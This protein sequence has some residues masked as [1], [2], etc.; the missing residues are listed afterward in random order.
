M[1][2]LMN[3]PIQPLAPEDAAS[4]GP[5]QAYTSTKDA[6]SS[7]VDA[8][9]AKAVEQGL[10]DPDTGFPTLKG[11]HEAAQQ[12][13]GALVAGT[14][15]PGV[16]AFHGSPHDFEAFDAG[17]IGTGEGAQAYG[18]GLYF[19]ENEG[20][21]KGYR[22]VLARAQ[23]PSDTVQTQQALNQAII[24]SNDKLAELL[25]SGVRFGSDE[26]EAALRP[27][28]QAIATL[29]EQLD[30]SPPPTGHMYEVSIN[31]NPDHFLDWD[32]PLSE[33]SRT[34]RKAISKDYPHLFDEGRYPDTLVAG[35]MAQARGLQAGTSMIGHN[36]V[37]RYGVPAKEMTGQD[38]WHLMARNSESLP[39]AS[40]ALKQAGIPGIRYLDQ[41][42][43]GA[44]E[45]TSNYVAFDAATIEILRKYGIAG[46][47]GAGAA[48]GQKQ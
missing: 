46:L 25:K 48:A 47:I 6:L 17:K 19:A 22:D 32:K 34:V 33:Q 2:S 28:Q 42:S 9:R 18:H 7:W 41:G 1:A 36:P 38:F 4:V 39:A 29:R 20:V 11:M 40:T 8:Q 12:Y 10:W 43:R 27:H 37:M 44:G 31:A 24:A 13:G 21:A 15:A 45:G 14:S 30:K 5:A 16:R 23:T 35:S 3:A 26:A